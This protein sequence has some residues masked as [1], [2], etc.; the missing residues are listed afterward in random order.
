MSSALDDAAE[1]GEGSS[2]GPHLLRDV[3]LVHH[4]EL[5]VHL[6]A[7]LHQLQLREGQVTEV[8]LVDFIFLGIWKFFLLHRSEVQLLRSMRCSCTPPPGLPRRAKQ[9]EGMLEPYCPRVRLL[10]RISA[11]SSSSHS[12]G[13]LPYTSLVFCHAPKQQRK[14]NRLLPQEPKEPSTPHF[15]F[16]LSSSRSIHFEAAVQFWSCGNLH[17]NSGCHCPALLL[18]GVQNL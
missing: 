14:R 16:G 15:C 18:N 2:P 4:S 10:T 7:A 11:S 1:G 5:V 9:G 13:S 12:H 8:K 3:E 17:S 6:Y